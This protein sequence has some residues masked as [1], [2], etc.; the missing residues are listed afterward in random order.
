[1]LSTTT[2]S[3]EIQ[4]TVTLVFKNS[5][6]TAKKKNTTLHHYK[7]QG[8]GLLPLSDQITVKMHSKCRH[9]KIDILAT[10]YRCSGTIWSTA[11][12]PIF[13]YNIWW[14]LNWNNIYTF[15]CNYCLESVSKLVNLNSLCCVLLIINVFVIRQRMFFRNSRHFLR[16]LMSMFLQRLPILIIKKFVHHY[17]RKWTS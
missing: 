16:K 13:K 3:I 10:V 14:I 7:D 9:L 2:K 15:I 1:V 4:R 17:I 8:D 12:R 6:C 5:I 11:C